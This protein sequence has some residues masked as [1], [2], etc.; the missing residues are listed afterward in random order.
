MDGRLTKRQP[1]KALTFADVFAGCGALSLG[2]MQAG[3]NGIFAVEQ[4]KFAFAT[5]RENLLSKH[6]R[7]RFVWPK[8]LPKEPIAIDTMLRSY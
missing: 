7:F 2:L 4:D 5:L 3:L 8:W 6:S 1:S